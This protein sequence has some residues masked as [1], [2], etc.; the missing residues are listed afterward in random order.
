MNER[1]FFT[2]IGICFLI[3]A[4][5]LVRGLQESAGN[6]FDITKDFQTEIELQNIADSALFETVQKI[7]QNRKDI[8]DGFIDEKEELVPE[9]IPSNHKSNQYPIINRTENGIKIDVIAEYGKL[10][11]KGTI[12]PIE[13]NYPS[14]NRVVDTFIGEPKKG[15]ILISVASREGKFGKVYRRSLA[16]VLEDKDGKLDDTKIYFMNDL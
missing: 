8:E 11:G 16:Y 6:Y 14:S 10:N 1:G 4:S 13:R 5:L 7:K 12:Y 9:S 2:L 3:V 15:I